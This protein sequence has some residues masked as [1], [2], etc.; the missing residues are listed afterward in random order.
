MLSRLVGENITLNWKPGNALYPV[1][2]DPSQFDQLL[3]KLVVNARDAITG[4]GTIT[5]ETA[6]ASTEDVSMIPECELAPENCVT[7]SITDNGSGMDEETRLHIFEPFYTTKAP[8]G[9]TGLGLATVYGIVRQNGGFI[10]VKSRPGEGTTIRVFLPGQSD[11]AVEHRE[12]RGAGP[13]EEGTETVLL[14]EDEVSVLKMTKTMLE[15]LGYSVIAAEAPGKALQLAREGSIDLLLT[16]VVMP[17]M[18]GREL[19]ERLTA[20]RPNLKCL[21]MS[22]YTADVMAQNSMLDPR[23]SLRF[24]HKPFTV[25]ELAEAVRK[26][27][28]NS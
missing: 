13:A 5:I 18:N 11:D 28:D 16:D 2:L 22:G 10:D 20:E 23:E 7:L 12:S 4:V 6:H 19:A 25:K 27:I 1:K 14:V 17:E 8:G 3:A 15:N 9:G 24:I 21:F 26:A